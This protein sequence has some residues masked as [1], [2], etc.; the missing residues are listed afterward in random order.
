M[1]SP[2]SELDIVH[3]VL[4]PGPLGVGITKASNGHCIVSSRTN[5][6]SPLQ[7]NDVVVSLNG[8]KLAA[9]DG[10]VQ[11]WVKLF[12]S[13]CGADRKL[14]VGRAITLAKAEVPGPAK[15]AVTA[16]RQ[17]PKTQSKAPPKAKGKADAAPRR[18]AAAPKE[19]RLKRFRSNPTISIQ[20][21][22]ERALTQRLYLIKTSEQTTCHMHGG[23]SITFSVL[24]STGNVYEVTLS[25]VPDCSC[26]DHRK[27]NLC[28]HLLFVALKVVGLPSS[29]PLVYQSA[30]LTEE[31]EQIFDLL[32]KRMRLV[33]MRGGAGFVANEAVQE[34]F[35]AMEEKKAAAAGGSSKEEIEED[36][37]AVKRK[38]ID[39]SE[40]PICFDDLGGAANVT[41]LTFCRAACGTNFHRDCMRMWT[42]QHTRNPT[43]PACRQP[44]TDAATGGKVS[45]KESKRGG[46]GNG[47]RN[48]EG[49]VNLGELQGQSPVRDTSTYSDYYGR[50]S[51]KR[52]RY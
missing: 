19:K 12:Q 14:V 40:C 3:L 5:A 13:L 24:G 32:Q 37:G 33:G 21:R 38:D 1:V 36:G 17:S 48:D 44:W 18:K 49:Y 43:C 45:P 2:S 25:K 22:I 16:A 46:S 39:G 47:G 11:A 20:Q 51:Y 35:T 27:G 23:P 41:Q 30:Y 34:K 31:L 4:P 15:A 29:S 7:V 8:I 6:S 26:P 10:G 9:V 52:R 42:S 50:Y 28:K